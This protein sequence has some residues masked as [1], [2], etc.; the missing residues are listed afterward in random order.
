MG[1]LET[2]GACQC[3]HNN[4]IDSVEKGCENVEPEREKGYLGWFLNL[5]ECLEAY[6]S[7]R[8][9]FT[10]NNIETRSVWV[11]DGV[12]W[13]NT[14]QG[15]P[16]TM[17]T[18]PGNVGVV[19]RGYAQTFYY[20]PTEENVEDVEVEFI[21]QVEGEEQKEMV[22]AYVN[23]VGNIV[24]LEWTGSTFNVAV[25]R[26]DPNVAMVKDV[27]ALHE[28]LRNVAERAVESVS[29]AE[30]QLLTDAQ[31]EKARK[32]IA[33]AA[34]QALKKVEESV[35]NI[36]D[37]LS[38]FQSD[39][40]DGLSWLSANTLQSV[41]QSLTDVQK[42]QARKN[43]GAVT[44]KN[45]KLYDANN[46]QFSPYT[47]ALNVYCGSLGY[48][49][50]ALS[51]IIS[52]LDNVK[53][54]VDAF[55]NDANLSESA[56]DTLKE[57]QE[58]I[59]SDVQA[60]A[61]MLANIN[62]LR[63]ALNTKVSTNGGDV[64]NTIVK[65][66]GDDNVLS[67][68]LV[69]S[70]NGF[71]QLA[72]ELG[73][74]A[75][76]IEGKIQA[77][78]QR[79]KQV[80]MYLESQKAGKTGY[81]QSMSVGVADNLTGRDEAI[82][83][84][85]IFDQSGG[86]NNNILEEDTAR[87]ESIQ[88]NSIVYEGRIINNNTT[89]I[90]TVGLN[91]VNTSGEILTAPKS[92]P[93]DRKTWAEVGKIYTG[94]GSGGH[95]A[96]NNTNPDGYGY[97]YAVR[98]DDGSFTVTN[99]GGNYGLGFFCKVL[100][101]ATYTSRNTYASP[102]FPRASFYDKN[103]LFLSQTNI[104]NNTFTTPYNC[105]YIFLVLFTLAGEVISTNTFENPVIHL[106]NTGYMDG[107]YTPY[108]AYREETKQ[109]PII[110]GGLRSVGDVCD[111]LIYNHNT[112][113]WEYIKRIEERAY[114]SG[115]E[116]NADVLT[117]GAI[118]YVK[119]EA[120]TITEL[121][122][123]LSPDYKVW[124]WGTEEAIQVTLSAPFRAK[125]KYGF[126]AVDQIRGNKINL[127][128]EVERATQA[129]QNL[130]TSIVTIQNAYPSGDPMHEA[131]VAAGAV[132]DE[133]TQTWSAN[134]RSGLSNSD[135]RSLYNKSD[136][137]EL[138]FRK[139]WNKACLYT[140]DDS[141][142][143][144]RYNEATGFYELNGVWDLTYDE[145]LASYSF[146]GN[147]LQLPA[148]SIS[149]MLRSSNLRTT[150]PR[151][152]NGLTSGICHPTVIQDVRFSLYSDAHNGYVYVVGYTSNLKI[153]YTHGLRVIRTPINCN[154]S[155]RNHSYDTITENKTLKHVM[156]YNF[157]NVKLICTLNPY[158]SYFSIHCMITNAAKREDLTI[159]LDTD[160][161][162]LINGTASPE[163]YSK[164]PLFINSIAGTIIPYDKNSKVMPPNTFWREELDV[165]GINGEYIYPS[166]NEYLANNPQDFATA[167]DWQA[168]AT[169][170]EEKGITI[171]TA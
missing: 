167:E 168:L 138:L 102:K 93:S 114:Q 146:I 119:A 48:L 120:E 136:M 113:K 128:K 126:N 50:T 44:E 133:A 90:K 152:A 134:G 54:D 92:L 22:Y 69:D 39:T 82:E 163:N 66:D 89:A 124:D 100:P 42:I 104:I 1:Y 2:I 143:M 36:R 10:F 171:T 33:A 160:T 29:Y 19:K 60:A 12:Q 112:D 95:T 67:E 65:I 97:S 53:G 23:S 32:N 6:P 84:E 129:E 103:K 16:M 106:K 52:K 77:E 43:I 150:L 15:N 101:N 79:A 27:E 162:N 122:I 149:S 140:N 135:V 58:Y 131:Y 115:D 105:E 94:I 86:V 153:G 107:K 165:K 61:Q 72:E 14:T 18:D 71:T 51:N 20:I 76:N 11:Y 80:E 141:F 37:V 8:K 137:D 73:Q 21:A 130:Q 57:I 64:S 55:F 17:I 127:E 45:G 155:S 70:A 99:N 75:S 158:I 169:L 47:D 91:I 111:E 88:G 81:Y 132:W 5:S 156:I 116:S 59:D 34:E 9:G 123:E 63:T 35:D 108:P 41:E 125:V 25:R 46:Q 142:Y 26:V 96:T 13:C 159:Q 121:D 24:F 85:F 144:G 31:K 157:Y 49:E 147:D 28:A 3:E 68:L 139:L 154:W 4:Y 109:L 7:P 170:A 166:F 164:E 30:T 161:Y 145:A 98:N 110:D 87:I 117:D 151:G 78:A 56:K 40:Q 148:H 38:H 83:R 118:T 62:E 74:T